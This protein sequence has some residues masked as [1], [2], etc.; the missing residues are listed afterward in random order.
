VPHGV[1]VVLVDSAAHQLDRN[2]DSRYKKK[3]HQKKQGKINNLRNHLSAS[4]TSQGRYTVPA[5][6]SDNRNLSKILMLLNVPRFIVDG[7]YAPLT[8]SPEIDGAHAFLASPF[9]SL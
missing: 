4:Y 2:Y 9:T 7:L 6:P 5:T 1:F 8:K 3:Q